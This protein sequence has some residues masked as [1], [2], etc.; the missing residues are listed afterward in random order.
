MNLTK[1]HIAIENSSSEVLKENQELLSAIFEGTPIILL[2]IDKDRRILKINQSGMQISNNKININTLKW[3]EALGCVYSIYDD[4]CGF[5]PI[6]KVCSINETILNTF[7]HKKNSYKIEAKLTINKNENTTEH[8]YHFSTTYIN[9][10]NNPSVLLAMDDITEQK[11]T[12]E[13]IFNAIIETEEKER[14]NF[15]ENLHDE[16]GPFLSGI[17]LYLNHLSKENLDNKKRIQIVKNIEGM[18]NES[19]IKTREISNSL[20]PHVLMDFGIKKALESYIEKINHTNEI[21][22]KFASDIETIKNQ[23]IEII[24]YRI[25][26]ELI[27]NT[28]KHANAKTIGLS[29]NKNQ[30]NLVIIYNDDGK[31]F[32]IDSEIDRNNGQ[33]LKNII[34]RLKT[35][36][37]KY[38]F[39]SAN[40]NG[41]KFTIEVKI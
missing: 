35:I 31:G 9:N 18:I 17:K 1:P 37:A 21:I 12:E 39:K 34:N 3:G 6:C 11:K 16:L 38:T 30:D 7:K 15:A 5:S 14:K 24:I 26:F 4:G 13:K 29:L 41:M 8:I 20:M 40:N 28:L 19:I 22:I 23:T 27:N 32:N 10:K 2:L 25:I 33:G 36:N